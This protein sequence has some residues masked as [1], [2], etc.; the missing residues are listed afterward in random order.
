[1]D[2]MK[3]TAGQ[4]MAAMKIPNAERDRYRAML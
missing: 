4:A 3:W 1:M 2:S